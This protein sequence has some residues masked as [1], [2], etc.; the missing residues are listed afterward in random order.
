M[1]V[2]WNWRFSDAATNIEGNS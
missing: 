1:T 2:Q